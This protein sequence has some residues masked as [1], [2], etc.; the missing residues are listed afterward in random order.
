MLIVILTLLGL[1]FGSF[2]NA[3]VWRLHEQTGVK[4]KHRG[5]KTEDLSV[6]KGRSMCPNCKHKLA[7]EDLLPMLSWLW[8]RGKCRYCHKPI[9]IQYPVIELLTA[10]L[11]VFSYLYWPFNWGGQ[12]TTLFIFWLIFLVGLTSLAIYDLR[13]QLLPNKIVYVL[14]YLAVVQCLLTVFVFHGGFNQIE[15]I[16]LSFAVGGGLFYALFQVS[17]GKWIGGGDVKLGMLLGLILA[18]P[19]LS[20]LMI[21]AASLLG[22]VV[23]LPL[24]AAHRVKRTS[25]IPFGPFLI[26]GAV[27]VRLFGAT[28]IHWYRSK[29]L[30]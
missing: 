10:V 16:A 25:R 21:F 18:S 23:S 14:L 22:S 7:A 20:L 15:N 11:F 4:G 1:C 26:A 6:L 17:N 2:V 12:G 29:L 9:S 19:S 5:A 8:L 27:I 28:L 24:L 13:W 30:I 3:L